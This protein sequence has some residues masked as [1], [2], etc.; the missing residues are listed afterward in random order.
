M[1]TR[2]CLYLK[3]NQLEYLEERRIKEA[4]KKHSETFYPIRL[5][6]EKERDREVTDDEE[7]KKEAKEKQEGEGAGN[8]KLEDV[9]QDENEEKK[10]KKKKTI[11]VCI[12][13]LYNLLIYE[14]FHFVGRK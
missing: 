14:I 11:K 6:V 12:T 1:G 3:E 9:G 5:L 4:V 13:V 2:V 7:E 10:G 8:S